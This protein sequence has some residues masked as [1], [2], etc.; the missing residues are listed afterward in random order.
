MA[1]EKDNITAVTLDTPALRPS[2]ATTLNTLQAQ[3]QA[4]L[5]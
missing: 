4:F 3:E 2:A 5:S 1:E